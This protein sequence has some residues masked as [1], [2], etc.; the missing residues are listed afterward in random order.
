M[1]VLPNC[2]EYD[3]VSEKR[4]SMALEKGN[5]VSHPPI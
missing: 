1:I 4:Q 5:R 2:R 3:E